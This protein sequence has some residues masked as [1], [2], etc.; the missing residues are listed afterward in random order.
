MKIKKS[1]LATLLFLLFYQWCLDQDTIIIG[2]ALPSTLFIQKIKKIKQSIAIHVIFSFVHFNDNNNY[3]NNTTTPHWSC[4]L[5]HL[6]SSH[7]ISL[8]IF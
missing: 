7:F 3:N 5:V 6:F 8:L 1:R 4:L 2:L